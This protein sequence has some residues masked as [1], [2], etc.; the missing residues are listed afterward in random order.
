MFRISD[1][2]HTS[3]LWQRRKTTILW[4]CSTLTLPLWAEAL[5][6]K[7]ALRHGPMPV[8]RDDDCCTGYNTEES[9]GQQSMDAISSWSGTAEGKATARV[10]EEKK[11]AAE[12]V[13]DL[14]A[15]HCEIMYS[16]SKEQT[17]SCH[18]Q[19]LIQKGCD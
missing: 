11:V 16:L 15:P 18:I 13:L 7:A 5:A 17:I 14:R 4:N 6:L 10:S 9:G 3:L 12:D 19:L 1:C 2:S 8:C